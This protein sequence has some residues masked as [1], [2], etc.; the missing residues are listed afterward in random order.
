MTSFMVTSLAILSIIATSCGS[1]RTD[2]TPKMTIISPAQDSVYKAGDTIEYSLELDRFTLAAPYNMR[3]LAKSITKHDGSDHSD[4]AS[5]TESNQAAAEETT[6]SGSSDET[7]QST[8]GSETDAE[9]QSDDPTTGEEVTPSPTTSPT[10]SSETS[11]EVASNTETATPSPSAESDDSM[12]HDDTDGST[13][14]HSHDTTA[15][16]PSAREGHYHVYLN[17]ASG[18]DPHITDWNY[19][20]SFPLPANLAPGTHSLRFELRD[21]EHTPVGTDWSEAVLFFVVE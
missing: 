4:D 18:S 7:G 10:S 20:G 14:T 8:A 6:E 21:N 19:T 17:D 12:T 9:P 1:T 3:S 13:D 15:T 5:G 11:D 2:T 16:N